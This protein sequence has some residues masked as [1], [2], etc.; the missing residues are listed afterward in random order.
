MM[1]LTTKGF[2][3]L[4]G[5]GLVML[6]VGL[7]GHTALAQDKETPVQQEFESNANYKVSLRAPHSVFRH[8]GAEV[9]VRVRNGQGQ[10]L[11]GV[12]VEFQVD[13]EWAGSASVSPQRVLTRNGTARAMLHIDTIGVV[14]VA[15]HVGTITKEASIAVSLYSPGSG[16][17]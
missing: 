5:F 9:V 8:E 13:P 11:D 10:P 14:N 12:P 2:S 7:L 15:A 6:L 4:W 1:V 3:A 17:D 16:S